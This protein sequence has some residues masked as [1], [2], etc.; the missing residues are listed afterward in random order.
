MR[1]IISNIIQV[2][3]P[4]DEIKK[5]CKD[6]L[7]IKNPDYSK[8]V[9]MGFWVANTPKT[10]KLYDYDGKNIYLPIGCF[11]DLY[12]MYPDNALYSDFSVSKTRNIQS[13]IILR[14]YQKPCLNALKTYCNGL[15]ILPCGLQEKQNA[16][17]KQLFI[18][19]NT[20]YS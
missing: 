13:S 5:Y 14:D 16:H 2:E 18:Y 20:L 7:T 12:K 17:Y 8:K 3:E 10:I 1:I 6:Q 19:N 9:Q 11:S 15:F 4:T